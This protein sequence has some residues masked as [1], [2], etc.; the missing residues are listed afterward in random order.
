MGGGGGGGRCIQL[1]LT[2]ITAE[3]TFQMWSCDNVFRLCCSTPC[4]MYVQY[5]GDIMMYVGDIL[6]TMGDIMMYMGVL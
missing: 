3:V 2:E 6:S 1:E 4:R 5:H